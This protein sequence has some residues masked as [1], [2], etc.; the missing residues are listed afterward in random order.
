MGLAVGHTSHTLPPGPQGRAQSTSWLRGDHFYLTNMLLWVNIWE[1]M[2][3]VPSRKAQD[4]SYFTE[5]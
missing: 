3:S 5:G 2:P 1:K 4:K